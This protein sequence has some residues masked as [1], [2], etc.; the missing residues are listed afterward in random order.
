MFSV[1]SFYRPASSGGQREDYAAINESA[2]IFAAFDGVSGSY[3][4][5]KPPLDYGDGETGGSWVA[6]QAAD[7]IFHAAPPCDID[8][9]LLDAN[10]RV[11]HKHMEL[12]KDPKKEAVAGAC[13]AACQLHEPFVSLYLAGDCFALYRNRTGVHFINDFDQAAVELEEAGKM[14]FGECLRLTKDSQHPHG[15]IGRAHDLRFPYTCARQHFRANKNIGKGG[16]AIL[17]GDPE[18]EACWTTRAVNNIGLKWMLL[19]TDGLLPSSFTSDQFGQL[20]EVYEKGGL[21]AVVQWHDERNLQL[22]IGV[23]KHPEASVVELKFDS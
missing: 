7:I 21:S 19:G 20:A 9:L 4:P 17:N 8:F 2:G 12:G 15:D 22:H 5:S 14:V 6:R 23:G 13:F 10:R 18:L 16:H 3:S 11:L 1:N